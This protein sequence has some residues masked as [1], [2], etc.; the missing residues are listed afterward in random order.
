M[1]RNYWSIAGIF[2]VIVLVVVLLE[3]LPKS[4]FSQF[5][6]GLISAI[7]A[8]SFDKAHSHCESL[9]T[10]WK[11]RRVYIA[12]ENGMD[13]IKDVDIGIRKVKFFIDIKDK[14]N[15]LLEAKLLGYYWHEIGE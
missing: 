6:D 3:W 11:K 14:N 1:A 13:L 8:E 9:A 12:F 15:A 2:L 4:R 10:F 7:E 5:L